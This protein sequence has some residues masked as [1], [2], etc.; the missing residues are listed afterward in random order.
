MD[1]AAESMVPDTTTDVPPSPPP[2]PRG[3]K[4]VATALVLLIVMGSVVTSLAQQEYWPFL[5]YAMYAQY[6]S[7]RRPLVNMRL[8]GIPLDPRLPEVHLRGS[9][10]TGPLGAA[11]LNEALARMVSTHGRDASRLVEAARYILDH[12]ERGQLT[13]GHDGPMLVGLR[14]VAVQWQLD[15][16]ARNA[17]EPGVRT[18]LFAYGPKDRL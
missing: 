14:L 7:M 13:G 6:H 8:Y 2:V 16:M 10:Q 12:Y 4:A 15:P 11:R 3:E 5:N 18:Q 17:G 1:T 9:A